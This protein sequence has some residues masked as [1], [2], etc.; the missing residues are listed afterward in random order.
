MSKHWVDIKMKLSK[1]ILPLAIFIVIS[2]CGGGGSEPQ[3]IV[4]ENNEPP[5]VTVAG[6]FEFSYSQPQQIELVISD[7]END[8]IAVNWNTTTSPSGGDLTITEGSSDTIVTVSA[9]VPGNYTIEAQISDGTNT[10]TRVI[11]L[12]IQNYS[13]EFSD[14]TFS[15]SSYNET[16]N[17][18]AIINN[19]DDADGDELSIVYSWSINGSSVNENT[20]TLSAG[21]A[22]PGDTVSVYATISDGLNT[23]TTDTIS[24][25]I[26]SSGTI[27]NQ[28]PMVTA[29]GSA[30][31][32]YTNGGEIAIEVSDP[33]GNP[34]S[35]SWI[36]LESPAN[37]DMVLNV[38]SSD[39]KTITAAASVPGEYLIQAQVSDGTNTVLINIVVNVTNLP[40]VYESVIFYPENPNTSNSIYVDVTG[41]SDPDNDVLD[42]TYIWRING[43]EIDV[44]DGYLDPLL[45]VKADVVSL[46]I[47][48]TDGTHEVET[49][50]VFVT[51]A[52]APPS[53]QTITATPTAPNTTQNIHADISGLED[54]D[55]DELTVTYTWTIN[56]ITNSETTATL[57]SGTAI[58]DDLV[59]VF[60][61]ITD[62][63]DSIETSNIEIAIADAPAV[64]TVT[65]L[66]T[67]INHGE[68][69]EFD[70]SMID[71]DKGTPE[72][73]TIAYGP[74]GMTID[75]SGHVTWTPDEVMFTNSADFN[76]GFGSTDP[77][78]ATVA[79]QIKVIDS[80]REIPVARS[81]IE[82]PY[83]NHSLWIDDFNDDG[84]NEILSTDTRNLIFTLEFD[85]SDYIQNWLYPFGLESEAIINQVIG[86][87]LSDDGVSDIIISAADGISIIDDQ[88]Q[89][90]TLLYSPTEDR[91]II[92][93]A[94]ADIDNDSVLEIAI[95]L[96]IPS[97]NSGELR[98]YESGQTWEL[99]FS[100]NLGNEGTSV[101]IGNAD[102][103]AALEIVTS[104]GHVYDGV[105]GI[106]EW[107]FS[108]GFGAQLAMGDINNDGVKVIIGTDRWNKPV[109]YDAINKSELWEINNDDICT[110]GAGNIDNDPQEEILVGNCQWG[111]VIAYDGSTGTP[112]QDALWDTVEHASVSVTIGDPD[113]DG[114]IE[115]IWG[116]G[117]TSTGEDVL[118][119]ADVTPTIEISWYNQDPAQLD[120]FAA[121][122]WAEIEPGVEKAV[123]LVPETNSGYDGQHFVTMDEN[124]T[125]ELSES[126]GTNWDRSK[127]GVAVDYD[128]DG[129][130]EIFIATAETYDG[131]F[132]VRQIND[133]SLKWGGN[134]GNYENDIKSIEAADVNNDSFIDAIVVDNN[135]VNIY[136]IKNQTIIWTSTSFGFD[137]LDVGVL[138]QDS[139][140]PQI[141]ISSDSETM[142]WAKDGNTYLRESDVEQA[143]RR[144]QATDLDNDGDEEIICLNY[145]SYFFADESTVTIYDHNFVELN[146]FSFEGKAEEFVIEQTTENRKNLLIARSIDASN[147][148]QTITNSQLTLMSINGEEIWNSPKLLD[149]I[150]HRSLFYKPASTGNKQLIF[151]TTD[152]M[153]ISK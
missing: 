114:D 62:G 81:G 92:A 143:C 6:S 120:L 19:L 133:Y 55:G 16:N 95:L 124:G 18:P 93:I 51:I 90:A 66:P 141:L 100:A 22:Q 82:I 97:E 3:N 76:F 26:M 135:I 118:V 127:Y 123:F 38:V 144:I 153:Y 150:P 73:V 148:W 40:P 71:P 4:E 72:Q 1:H 50:E 139:A 96:S 88:S 104:T 138:N 149:P 111:D 98:V 113:N 116:S 84:E 83:K 145:E 131:E 63:E 87:D 108:G 69:L 33:D 103:D 110:L 24:T 25:S 86:A 106:N 36:V 28:P 57:P 34:V 80:N 30:D 14:I 94:I 45:A 37:G 134:G 49:E 91:E 142:I 147:Y 85:G 5:A 130:A 39:F 52:N 79:N 132:Q 46:S 105:T 59:S 44:E 35:I 126:V 53:F 56:G 68:L 32:S 20:D 112:V 58:R 119:V 47:I 129:Y 29:P 2:G 64:A 78:V 74:S 117:F 128:D 122:G 21:T 146:Q 67:Q 12:I 61:T 121:A 31:I 137:V 107:F 23:I 140:T 9:T 152:A 11:D 75:A 151:A 7:P 102:N 65:G 10:V 13:P 27:A 8:A 17:I 109:V 60:A 136:D 99:E 70:V 89:P 15:E 125:F 54:I 77:E 41:V 48:I 43:V 42:G 101:L 115:V